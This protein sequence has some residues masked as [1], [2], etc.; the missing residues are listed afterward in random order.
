[1][2]DQQNWINDP[3]QVE[4]FKKRA[5]EG[6]MDRRTFLRILAAATAGGVAAACGPAVTPAPTTAP[7]PPAAVQP[8]PTTPPVAPPPAVAQP[9]V[10]PT[11][12][13]PAVTQPTKP[14]AGS[15][16]PDAEQILRQA[17]GAEPASMDFNA[18]LYCNGITAL[19]AGLMN[20]DLDYKAVPYLAEKVDV[21]DNVWTFTLKSG[22]KWNNGDPVT[23]KDFD[24]SWRRQ[25]HPA[26]AA[27]YAAL[28][29]DVK[30]AEK[31]NQRKDLKGTQEELDKAEVGIVAK[32]DTT[33]EVTLEGPRG[34]FGQ[35][36]AYIAAL[37]NHRP[38]IEKN[39]ET[40]KDGVKSS[41]P[42]VIVSNGPYKLTKWDHN[43]SVEYE[44]WDGF[45]GGK[46][47]TIR[48]VV[49]PIIADAQLMQ[50]YEK[51]EI[52]RAT[53]PP[54]EVKRVQA[55]AKMSKELYIYSAT[56]AFYLVPNPNMKPFDVK[57]VRRAI[58]HAI[59][60]DAIVKN[61]LQ[62]VGK[63]AFTFDPPDLP[64]YV[65]PVKYPK[66]AELCKFDKN[67]ALKELEGTPYAG[68]KNWPKIVLT[69][70]TNEER[71]GS[72]Q[73]VQAIQ[74][75]LKDNLN[76]DVELEPLE[77]AVFRP[78]MWDH[79]I[80]FTWVRWYSD[81]PDSN[82]NLYQVWYSGAGAAGHRHDFANPAFDK[83]VTEAKSL[84]S[85]DERTKKYAEAEIVGLEDGYATYVYYL[86]QSRVYKP[87]VGGL[88]K[89][90]RGEL[91]QDVNIFFDML[92]YLR[93]VEAE[94]RPKLS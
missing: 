75:M 22:L 60:R 86:Y 37:P 65:D 90:S 73:A 31:F 14:A 56:G 66:I 24:W 78:K 59:D 32:N 42:G 25:L 2:S 13:P 91:V 80:Q 53:I 20:F 19:W 47:A 17:I 43:K 12:A 62:N 81:Y 46:K 77:Q 55:D 26:T 67:L 36:V 71:I 61:V 38:T 21:K 11:A 57:G 63:P 18:N 33:L 27:P 8:A 23:A 1:M 9:T 88:P 92:S 44:R 58:N 64:H 93:I 5:T 85:Q 15:P 34:Y 40:F 3:E 87:W 28:F 76:M 30:G 29:Y 39:G 79:K 16:V 72:T 50:S 41:Q 82:N 83:L 48:K 10:A 52:D 69:Y 45:T 51:N 6:N 54:S 89:N 49:S 35:I 68:G 94:G 70:R 4:L 84:N 74:A 7:A